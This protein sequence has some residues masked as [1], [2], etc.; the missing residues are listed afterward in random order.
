MGMETL[1]SAIAHGAASEIL[2]L[3]LAPPDTEVTG[4]ARIERAGIVVRV[5]IARDDG[6]EAPRVEPHLTQMQ[7]DILE[8]APGRLHAPVSVRRLAALSGYVYN[9]YF[10]GAVNLL[11]EHGM[12]VRVPGGVRRT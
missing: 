2:R 6:A 11:I 3:G 10:R 12:M 7:R 4:A 9:S 8:S 1:A 5:I